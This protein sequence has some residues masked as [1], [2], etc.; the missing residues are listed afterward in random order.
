MVS[1]ENKVILDRPSI[2]N[3]SYAY[4]E[5][6]RKRNNGEQICPLKILAVSVFYSAP[7]ACALLNALQKMHCTSP[8]RSLRQLL[9]CIAVLTSCSALTDAGYSI[10]TDPERPKSWARLGDCFKAKGFLRG[11]LLAYRMAVEISPQPDEEINAR[12][13]VSGQVMNSCPRVA[14]SNE[15]VQ[16][17]VGR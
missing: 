15:R 9:T 16:K 14:S 13:T 12:I 7:E 10:D 11:A 8:W 6:L 2:E 17:N 4:A 5:E 3:M 1:F